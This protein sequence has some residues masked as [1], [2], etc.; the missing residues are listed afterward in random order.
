MGL[1]DDDL[2]YGSCGPYLTASGTRGVRFVE[3]LPVQGVGLPNGRATVLRP[4]LLTHAARW[5]DK[6]G[7]QLGDARRYLF[8]HFFTTFLL[9]YCSWLRRRRLPPAVRRA[10]RS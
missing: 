7:L 4:A 5:F 10:P 8:R 6:P 1:A 9:S 2:P 3:H